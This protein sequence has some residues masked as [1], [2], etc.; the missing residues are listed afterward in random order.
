[1]VAYAKGAPEVILASCTRQLTEPTARRRSTPRAASAILETARQ[2]ASE[3]LR[4]LAVAAKPDATL[5]TAEREMT[6]L[7]LV[8]MI[9]PPRPEAQGRDPDLRAGRHQGR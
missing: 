5:E 1:M 8:G 7:G 9:D 4:V 3:A 6:F 2:M